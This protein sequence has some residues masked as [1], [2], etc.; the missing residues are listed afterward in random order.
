[1][2]DD[3]IHKSPSID[4]HKCLSTVEHVESL[5]EAV[6]ASGTLPPKVIPTL[7]TPLITVMSNLT[8]ATRPSICPI[9][10]CCVSR[11]IYLSI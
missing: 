7:T 5:S 11:Y 3:K 6:Q 1:M 2:V 8:Y 9:Q 4:F 10:N